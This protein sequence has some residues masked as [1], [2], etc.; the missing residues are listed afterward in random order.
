MLSIFRRQSNTRKNILICLG[1]HKHTYSCFIYIIC[2]YLR[3][4]VST[5]ISVSYDVRAVLPVKR[6]VS[7]VEQVLL[8][9]P[10]NQSSRIHTRF[11]VVFVLR[12]VLFS[13]QCFVDHCLS[14][15]PIAFGHCIACSS[16]IHVFWLL[17]WYLQTFDACQS[18]K[19]RNWRITRHGHNTH[20]NELNGS[21]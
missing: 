11:P 3:I 2:I 8:T 7:V 9:F 6:R 1:R 15:C 10:D 21:N 5:T 16:S 13:V 14:F 4:L 18:N 19:S 17:V 20:W 12:N